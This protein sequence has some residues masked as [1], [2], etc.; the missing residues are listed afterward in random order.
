MPASIA[1]L[2][3]VFT[4]INQ[5]SFYIEN[6]KFSNPKL[7]VKA[8]KVKFSTVEPMCLTSNHKIRQSRQ[9]QSEGQLTN[10]ARKILVYKNSLY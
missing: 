6:P 8:F 3:L 5:K 2:F 9:L 7:S 4:F 10:T 1:M